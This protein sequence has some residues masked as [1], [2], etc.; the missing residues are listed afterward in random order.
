M[1]AVLAATSAHLV[2]SSRGSRWHCTSRCPDMTSTR[3]RRSRRRCSSSLGEASSSTLCSYHSCWCRCCSMCYR[4]TECTTS[5]RRGLGIA[6][7]SLQSMPPVRLIP[8]DRTYQLG[9][10]RTAGNCQ[11]PACRSKCP[12]S[13]PA[14]L[15]LRSGRNVQGHIFCS[16]VCPQCLGICLP[17]SVCSFRFLSC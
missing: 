2:Q 16:S 6:P 10:L 1:S 12:G 9:S 5:D 7:Q 13:N 11:A 15:L 14:P 8:W 3:R 17:R 4:Y